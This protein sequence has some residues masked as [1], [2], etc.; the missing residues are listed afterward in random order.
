VRSEYLR[1]LARRW[2]VPG[3]ETKEMD[4]ANIAVALL[5]RHADMRSDADR[6]ARSAAAA[7]MASAAALQTDAEADALD[8]RAVQALKRALPQYTGACLAAPLTLPR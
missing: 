2:E 6:H 1:A 3:A 4:R 8:M 5:K 7:A